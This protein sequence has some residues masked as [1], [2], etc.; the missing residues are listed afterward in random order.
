MVELP[1]S[2]M[3]ISCSRM[4]DLSLLDNIAC[5][6][7]DDRLFLPRQAKNGVAK[8]REL[9]HVRALSSTDGSREGDHISAKGNGRAGEHHTATKTTKTRFHRLIEDNWCCSDAWLL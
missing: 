6:S 5:L 4:L 9:L 7:G 3:K 8:V 1:T 2:P